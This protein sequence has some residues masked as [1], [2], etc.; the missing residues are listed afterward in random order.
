MLAL[1]VVLYV[2]WWLDHYLHQ[3]GECGPTGATWLGG[4]ATFATARDRCTEMIFCPSVTIARCLHL[5]LQVPKYAF[6][7]LCFLWDAC[8]SCLDDFILFGAFPYYDVRH[9]IRCCELLY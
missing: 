1:D 2:C 7:D 3:H 5:V 9:M 4:V 6:C 8:I